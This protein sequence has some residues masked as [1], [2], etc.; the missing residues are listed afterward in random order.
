M[1]VVVAVVVVFLA[2][3]KIQEISEKNAYISTVFMAALEALNIKK[4][5]KS[6]VTATQWIL[7][8]CTNS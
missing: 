3:I 2:Y 5:S 8:I 6:Y 4:Q 7:D 1:D